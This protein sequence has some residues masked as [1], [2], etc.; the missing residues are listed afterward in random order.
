M[1]RLYVRP[2]F[3]GQKLGRRLAET[4]IERARSAGHRCVRLDT[5]PSMGEAI[6]LY[7]TL[8]FQPIAP[9][10]LNPVPGA[11]FLELLL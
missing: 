11:M 6:G 10:R 9:Y 2:A 3:R 7:R 4:T 8:G 1:K 5:M